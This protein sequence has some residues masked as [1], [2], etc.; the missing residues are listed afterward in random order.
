LLR[1]FVVARS[2]EKDAGQA[3]HDRGCV[4]GEVADRLAEATADGT[5]DQW[6]ASL[7][8]GPYAAGEPRRARA[9][10]SG[11]V[12]RHDRLRSRTT[13]K[14]ERLALQRRFRP[15]ARPAFASH[16]PRKFKLDSDARQSAGQHSPGERE[17]SKIALG[18]GSRRAF[19]AQAQC[20]TL[21]SPEGEGD[22]VAVKLHRCSNMWVKVGGHPCWRVQKALDEAGI[23]YQVVKG[24]VL[25]RNRDELEQLSGQRLYPVIEFA[26]G[27]LY[28]EPSTDMAA[29]ISAGTLDSKRGRDATS[30]AAGA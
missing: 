29:T 15:P 25:R 22:R 27:S 11:L 26:D 2:Q 16:S 5:A 1:V 18:S 23:E 30:G 6:H 21:A 12:L 17:S 8:R 4:A 10:A 9:A 28:R 3:D 13:Q 19:A 20:A 7:E 14:A 24:P